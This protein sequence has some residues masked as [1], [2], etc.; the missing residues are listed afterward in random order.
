[1]PQRDKN[2]YTL[3][4]LLPVKEKIKKVVKERIRVCGSSGKM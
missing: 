3:E 2:P 4:V 1:F